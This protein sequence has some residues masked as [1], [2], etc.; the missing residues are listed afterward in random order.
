MLGRSYNL[1]SSK[2]VY[3]SVTKR[4]DKIHTVLKLLKGGGNYIM[5]CQM[6]NKTFFLHSVFCVSHDSY[7]KQPL[8][9]Y[10][11][12]SDYLLT[13]LLHGAEPLLKS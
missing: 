3:T 13:Y 12:S 5:Y 11:T 9:P 6:Q 8:V 10:T 1:L 7:N 2:V 4:N